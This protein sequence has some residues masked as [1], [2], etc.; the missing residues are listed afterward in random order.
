VILD[1]RL[2]RRS[3]IDLLKDI[4]ENPAAPIVMMI[5]NY[6]YRQYRVG[7]MAAGA[8]Y[9]FSKTDEFEMIRETLSR[10]GF[11]YQNKIHYIRKDQNKK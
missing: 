6:P 2:P 8:D 10:I 4:K 5:T 11:H 7:C 9:F 1:I 3:G